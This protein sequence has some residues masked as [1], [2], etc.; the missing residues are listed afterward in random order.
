MLVLCEFAEGLLLN[1]TLVVKVVAAAIVE[2]VI[3]KAEV[4]GLAAIRGIID[5]EVIGMGVEMAMA[6][7][8][9]GISVWLRN[10][11]TL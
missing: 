8:I 6:A 10:R 2:E 4:S 7:G 11:A 9:E 1:A 3:A 5:E